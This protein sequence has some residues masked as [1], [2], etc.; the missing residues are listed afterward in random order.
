M[1]QREVAGLQR[2]HHK[3]ARS[4]RGLRKGL[5]P[6]SDAEDIIISQGLLLCNRTGEILVILAQSQV[7]TPRQPWHPMVPH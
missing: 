4:V 1:G 2:K 6:T 7:Q 3:A 5:T